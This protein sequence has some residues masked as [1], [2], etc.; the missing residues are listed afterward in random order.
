[1]TVSLPD[2]PGVIAQPP[3]IFLATMAIGFALELAF[4][5]HFVSG[6][7]RLALGAGLLGAGF[8]LTYAAIGQQRRAGTNIETHRPTET[9]VR[10]GLY[11]FSRNP[12]YIG[13]VGIYLGISALADSVWMLGLLAPLLVV[14]HFGVIAREEA[15]LERKFG[16][17]YRSYR[18]SVRRWL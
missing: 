18:G 9:I 12:I 17:A 14:M 16:D 4:P 3:R 15:Y 5:T 6:L 11:R 2:N 10:D 13:L 1:M 8:W 7:V